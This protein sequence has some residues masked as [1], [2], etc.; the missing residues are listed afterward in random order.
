MRSA[1]IPRSWKRSACPTAIAEARQAAPRRSRLDLR[2][3]VVPGPLPSIA[4]AGAGIVGAA[5]TIARRR[6]ADR[7]VHR[8][9]ARPPSRRHARGCGDGP[10]RGPACH[11]RDRGRQRGRGHWLPARVS[12]Y[13][14]IPF[15]PMPDHEGNPGF[16]TRYLPADP[17]TTAPDGSQVR[18]LLSLAAGSA[19]H[20]QLATGPRPP[21]RAVIARWR[22]SGTSSRA[23]ARCGGVTAP[24]K[25]WFRSSPTSA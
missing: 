2:R 12:R 8:G 1:G 9:C 16:G 25:R 5:V 10:R 13:G 11:R 17:D 6:D 22:R 3:G 19:A 24:A 21:G 15:S 14:R 7:R 4:I 18:V 23:E 20:F